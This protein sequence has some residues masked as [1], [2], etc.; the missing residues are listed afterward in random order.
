MKLIYIFSFIISGLF[1]R[2]II[3]ESFIQASDALLLLFIAVTIYQY[4]YVFIFSKRDGNESSLKKCFAKWL[5]HYSIVLEAAVAVTFILNFSFRRTLLDGILTTNLLI[6]NPHNVPIVISTCI[7]YQFLYLVIT[8][9][10][11]N[12]R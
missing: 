7:A 12:G 9:I 11:K 4:L 5:L 6:E 10:K 2:Y 3:F 1:F 8:T